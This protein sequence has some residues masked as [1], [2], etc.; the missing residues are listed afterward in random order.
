MYA[1]LAIARL[2]E[3]ISKRDALIHRFASGQTPME[4]VV[5]K[6]LI[7]LNHARTA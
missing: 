7:L 3:V 5:S 2:R 4:L 1:G 6:P